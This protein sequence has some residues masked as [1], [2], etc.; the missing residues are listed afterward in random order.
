[1][2]APEV[3]MVLN[4]FGLGARP[5]EAEAI[6]SSPDQW[7][8]NQ[9]GQI[10]PGPRLARHASSV[11]ILNESWA[12]AGRS[13][14]IREKRRTARRQLRRQ[15]RAE[16]S[17]RILNAI[18]TDQPFAE[19]LVHF[20]SN[21]F[22]VSSS[23]ATIGTAVGAY[24]REAIRPH[25]F[26]RFSDMLLAVCQHPC[27]LVYLDNPQSVGS[28]S[29]V[30]KRRGRSI[31]EN[32]AREVLELHTVGVNGGYSQADVI[33]LAEALSGW[34]HGGNPGRK[35][36]AKGARPDARFRFVASRHQPGVKA[37]L[38]KRYADDGAE[39][40]RAM[41]LDLAVRTETANFIA[42][43]LARHFFA[44]EPPERFVRRLSSAFEQTGGD[45]A[46]VSRTLI[47]LAFEHA[48]PT[49]Q[50]N[51]MRKLKTPHELMVSAY[52]SLNV[53]PAR[54]ARLLGAL[55]QMGHQPFAAL[56][57]AG[58]PDVSSYWLTPET[59]LRRVEWARAAATTLPPT[60]DP[61][62][63]L[64]TALGELASDTTSTWVARAPSPVEAVAMV[65]ASHEFQWR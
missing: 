19:R 52:R 40:A 49:E 41:L 28:E 24:E 54:P 2:S 42:H 59:L 32:L 26:G 8:F 25:V 13:E 11:Q 23:R 1:M 27:M 18:E 55:S 31:N 12:H 15:F 60:I 17:D 58:W 9:V 65:L 29:R 43:K 46:A 10:A 56:S 4:R 63:L 53:L 35:A 5:G 48:S 3:M 14:A 36:R 39:Q 47:A 62:Q 51:P 21:H 20:W 64:Q 45:L 57:P 16:V 38:G 61:R 6:A 37:L 7:L 33:A 22:S 44:D 30:G 34:S 50:V